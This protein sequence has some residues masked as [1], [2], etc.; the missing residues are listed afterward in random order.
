MV[1]CEN[2]ENQPHIVLLYHRSCTVG[3]LLV[4]LLSGNVWV[5]LLEGKFVFALLN[6]ALI[7]AGL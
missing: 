3:V 4:K 2:M 6:A 5:S 1:D 7:T